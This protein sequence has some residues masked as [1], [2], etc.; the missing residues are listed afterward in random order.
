MFSLPVETWIGNAAAVLSGQWGAVSQR[1]RDVEC[2]REAMYQQA[3]RVEQAVAREQAGGPSGEELL[4]EN[5]RL[6]DENQTLWALL[7]EAESLS[8]AVQQ[9]FAATASAMGLSLTQIIRLLAMVLP[10]GCVPSRATVGRWVEQCGSRAGRILK[11]LDRACQAWVL[12]LCLD[13]I[14]FHR[15]PVLV[16]V[17]ADSMTWVAGQRGPDRTGASWC[18]LLQQWPGLERVVSDAGTGLGRGV[19]LLNEARAAAA[20]AA[21]AEQP[22]V[23]PVQ[24][25]L[26]VFHTERE[27]QRIVG[28]RWS[29]V[30]KL[31]EAA[32]QA[33][34]EV[35]NAKR[36]G[37]DARGAAARARA[38]WGKAERACDAAVQ[39]EAAVEG[40]TAALALVRA[41]GQ[42]NDRR[43]AQQQITAALGQLAGE[44]WSKVR[45]LLNDARTLNHLDWMHEQLEQAVPDPV[46]REAVVRLWYWRGQL[47]RAHGRQ[48][49]HAVQMVVMAQLLCRRLSSEWPQA[50]ARVGHILTHTVR[51]SSAVE[52]MN[53]VLRMHQ[54]RHRQVSQGML[55]LKRLYWNCRT[56]TH[57]KRRG[58]SPYQ[59]LG[60]GLPTDDWWE[61]LQMDPE[62]LE[63]KLS[64]QELMA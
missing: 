35:D 52:C 50:Y 49:T 6:R 43:W 3:R 44:A 61:L 31:V 63:Q 14:F 8:Q 23:E 16:A 30:E 47:G 21:Q 18:R 59:L 41:D 51:A 13:E 55:D 24:V 45:R 58:T 36:R 32:A 12:T 7:E 26:D 22:A 38:A 46:L 53:S 25:G 54:A 20:A 34:Q 4:A 40:I 64:T 5:Q 10:S 42:L 15:E 56:F 33:E 37:M 11:V 27:M 29:Q 60:I 1:A 17:E 9:K 57:G 62:E 48:Q 39:V 19:K 28:R 2:S